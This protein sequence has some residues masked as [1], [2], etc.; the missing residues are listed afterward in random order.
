ME[1][2]EKKKKKKNK[3]LELIQEITYSC[4]C[5]LEKW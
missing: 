1:K 3:L 5:N 2:N 4:I